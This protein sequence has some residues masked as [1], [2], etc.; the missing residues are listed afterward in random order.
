MAKII[1][2]AVAPQHPPLRGPY[3][4]KIRFTYIPKRG[5]T[6]NLYK[7]EPLKKSIQGEL[8]VLN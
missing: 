7:R 3:L 4:K 8:V 2:W 6:M 1:G 5:G